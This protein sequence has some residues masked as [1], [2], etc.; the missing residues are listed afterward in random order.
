MWMAVGTTSV[1]YTHLVRVGDVDAVLIGEPHGFIN[2]VSHGKHDAIDGEL[3]QL[4]ES[5]RGGVFTFRLQLI[6]FHLKCAD[7]IVGVD[8]YALR[9]GQ[10]T[11]A[12]LG[13]A[14]CGFTLRKFGGHTRQHFV[15]MCIR[16]SS[17]CLRYSSSVVAPMH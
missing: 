9:G 16:D 12:H 3:I 13:G 4:F 14:A 6:F 2:P 5:D 7:A 11:K 10:K 15:E 1:S 17:M 8:Q